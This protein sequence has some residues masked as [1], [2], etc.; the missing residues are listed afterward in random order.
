MPIINKQLE[1][2]D[3]R[4]KPIVLKIME[5]LEVRGHQPIV[6]EGR[7]TLAQQQE[8]VRLRYSKTLQ[9][10]HLSGLAADIIDRR[11]AWNIPLHHKFWYDLGHI[12]KDMKLSQGYLRWGGV[13]DHGDTRWPIIE[14]AQKNQSDKNLDWFM[15]VAHVEMRI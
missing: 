12:I 8:K 3:S 2:L 11:L 4:F 13:W 1:S 15:D 10:Y 9:S 5:E 7:R 14:Q 6:A